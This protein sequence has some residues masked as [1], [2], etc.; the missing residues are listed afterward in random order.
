MRKYRPAL[1]VIA[2]T[3]SSIPEGMACEFTNGIDIGNEIVT[4]AERSIELKLLR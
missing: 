1:L 2:Q 3:L 4:G